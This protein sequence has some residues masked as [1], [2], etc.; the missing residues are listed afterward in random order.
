MKRSLFAV[1]TSALFV[2]Y[3]FAT[4]VAYRYLGTIKTPL[5]A[6]VSVEKYPNEPEMLLI[7]SFG[8]FS[9][10]K[11]SM[12]PRIGDV[13]TNKTFSTAQAQILADNYKWPNSISTVPQDVFGSGIKAIVVPDGFLPPGKGDGNVFVLVDENGKWFNHQ[14]STLKSGYFYH[15]GEWVDINGD[16][17]KDFL[18]ARTNAQAGSGQLVWFEHPAEGLNKLP[19]TEHVVTAGPDVMFE[20]KDNLKGYE[21]SF[22]VFASEFFNKKLTVYEFG[23]GAVNGGKLINSRVIDV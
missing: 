13:L 11:V 1:V 10:G 15:A 21:N 16:G 19:W 17:R 3:G 6:F 14:I 23:K 4:D 9:A 12:I 2:T 8:A 20:V 22:V 5:P 7:S 18:S